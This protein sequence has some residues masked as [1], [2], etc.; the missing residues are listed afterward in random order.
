MN[1]RGLYRVISDFK[2]GYQATTNREKD[3]KFDLVTDSKSIL[4]RCRNHFSQVL[5]VRGVND[6]RQTEI[7][8][9]ESLV[10]EPS[11]FNF[12]LAIGKFKDTNHHVIIK[13]RQ[14]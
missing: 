1:I 4:A 9:T 6:I 3:E 13:S 11:D 7:H 10:P 14:N 2:K 8:A 5:N 12:E